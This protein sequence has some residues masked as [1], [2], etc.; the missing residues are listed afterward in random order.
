MA[1]HLYGL[2]FAAIIDALS[3]QISVLLLHTAAGAD[4][5]F[6]LENALRSDA[7]IQLQILNPLRKDPKEQQGMAL[8]FAELEADLF[9][10]TNSMAAFLPDLYARFHRRKALSASV[11]VFA[12]LSP[13]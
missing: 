4:S 5:S 9:G 8:A 11:V 3:S 1:S 6:F 7:R 12:L 10:S 13:T 2:W